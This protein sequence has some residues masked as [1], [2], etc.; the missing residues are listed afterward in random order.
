MK[1]VNEARIVAQ[2]R[3]A[4]L[5][6]CSCSDTLSAMTGEARNHGLTGAEIDAALSGR[7]FEAC[8]HAAITYACAIKSG[9]TDAIGAARLRA[10]RVGLSDDELETIATATRRLLAGAWL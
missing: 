8:S 1:D 3:L 6:D 4:L 5:G 10:F 9:D 2:L 7:S